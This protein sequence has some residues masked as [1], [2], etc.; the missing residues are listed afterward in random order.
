[1]I[2][3]KKHLERLMILFFMILISIVFQQIY[4]SMTEQGI[5]SGGPYDNSA[6]YP[7]TVAIIVAILIAAQLIAS[8]LIRSDTDED[9]DE[10]IDI[11]MFKRP[12]AMLGIFAIY[13]ALLTPLGYH[14]TTTPLMF[15]VVYIT[16]IRRI[17]VI[18]VVSAVLS[19]SFAF[20][21]EFFLKIVL[22][23]GMFGLNIAW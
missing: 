5:A 7:R 15:C 14:L 13:L 19:F 11:S 23:G 3:R 2:I 12:T 18:A 21:F 1:M 16:G 9:P 20:M 17:P 4:T 8:K 22:P 6:A 10:I